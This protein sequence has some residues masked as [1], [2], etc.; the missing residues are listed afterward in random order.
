MSSPSHIADSDN[1]D[2]EQ[3]VDGDEAETLTETQTTFASGPTVTASTPTVTA[4]GPTVIASVGRAE[5][6]AWQRRSRSPSIEIL[7][8]SDEE[9]DVGKKL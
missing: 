9:S 4:P 5:S 8:E 1:S 3:L 6:C 7:I 2:I